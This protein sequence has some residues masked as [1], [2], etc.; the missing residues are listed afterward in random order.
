MQ[1]LR[2]AA[3]LGLLL[4]VLAL[5]ASAR[6]VP[7]HDAVVSYEGH[8]V[9]R[10][11]VP[12]AARAERAKLMAW[13][14]AERLD[15]WGVHPEWVD[16]RLDKAFQ[17]RVS[18]LD[19]PFHVMVEDLNADLLA[20]RASIAAAREQGSASAF[21]DTFRT[22]DEF[23]TYLDS[24]ASTYPHLVTKKTIGKTIEG[25]AINGIVITAPSNKT[26]KVG[27]VFNGG[28]HA[29]EWIGPMTNAY[30]A[31]QLLSL[32]DQDALI[33]LF[34][35]EIEWSIF[36]IINA[37]GYVYSWTNERLWRKNRRENKNSW[38]GCYG[39]DI[40]RNWGFHWGEGGAS[41]DTCSETYRGANAFSEPEQSA[42][43]EYIKSQ[44]N[45]RGY[46]DWH[47][48]SQLILGPWGWSTTV[49]PKDIT[50]QNEL[51]KLAVEAIKSVHGK[52]YQYGPSGPTLYVSSGGSNDYTYG[53][54]NVTYS[55]VVELRDTG[56]YGFVLPPSEI[57]PTGE[58]SFAAVRVFANYIL[59]DL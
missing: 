31:N 30:I 37:D 17:A 23:N 10:F 55:Y 34:L 14:E 54:L 24:L 4:A 20:E 29:R 19:L 36:P 59:R 18:A 50:K 25:R 21:F 57:V 33:T 39:V 22:Y 35:D 43:A 42:L 11:T 51:A 3:L 26:D 58:E 53:A 28:Q 46:I 8:Q 48:Y 2:R 6:F 27:I 52:A 15:M 12:S 44:A 5:C 49:L 41:T 38:F 7:A 45:V 47:S 40:N 1:H 13:I 9:L 56:R 32:Y 16:V